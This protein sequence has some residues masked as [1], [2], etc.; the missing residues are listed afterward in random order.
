MQGK[1]LGLGI[2]VYKDL[3]I[4]NELLNPC[5]PQKEKEILPGHLS[6]RHAGKLL[7]TFYMTVLV[8]IY[9]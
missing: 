2:S 9:L 3:A 5:I 8:R 6:L 1:E 7:K 4:P